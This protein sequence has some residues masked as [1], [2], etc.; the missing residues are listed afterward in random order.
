[1]RLGNVFFFPDF[2]G[3]FLE[4]ANAEPANPL[5]TPNPMTPLWYMAPFYGML[6]AIPHKL[7]GVVT[8]ISAMGVLFLVPWLDNSSVRSMRYKGIYSRVAFRF[9]VVSFVVLGYLGIHELTPVKQWM[10]QGATLLYFAYFLLMPLYTRFEST[11]P[12]PERGQ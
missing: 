10:A 3:Y 1:M 8:M 7:C 5:V 12:L 9:M 11:K 2:G 4:P 6:R